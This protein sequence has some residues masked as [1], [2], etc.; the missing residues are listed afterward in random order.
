MQILLHKV[1]STVPQSEK[2]SPQAKDRRFKILF[3]SEWI[4]GTF[5]GIAPQPEETLSF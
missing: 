5:M 1:K 3:I 4:C 2:V